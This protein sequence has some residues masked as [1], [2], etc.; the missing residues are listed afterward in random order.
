MLIATFG[1]TT[2]WAG[3]TISRDGDVFILEGHGPISASDVMEYDRQGHLVWSNDGTRAWVG[4]RA[5]ATKE[6]P[7][8]SPMSEQVGAARSQMTSMQP[9]EPSPRETD[10][11]GGWYY[12]THGTRVGPLSEGHMLQL[13]AAGNVDNA[14]HVW[15]QGFTDWIPIGETA[16]RQT[17]TTPPPL[18]GS[19]VNNGLV[20]TVAFV[21]LAGSLLAVMLVGVAAASSWAVTLCF[22][23]VNVT[24]C[25]VDGSVLRKAGYDTSTF[26]AWVILIPVYLYKRA[27][28]LNQRLTYF[29]VWMVC[30]FLSLFA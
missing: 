16:L 6:Q 8:D 26:G 22:L 19:V 28:A 17:L 4:S 11:D 27:K 13:L 1:P 9:N 14:T 12:A 30:F 7:A 2:A 18:P 24:L 29:V 25:A 15:R 23:A 21:P 5:L 20:W 3:K 10:R